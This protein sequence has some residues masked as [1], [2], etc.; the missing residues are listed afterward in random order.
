MFYFKNFCYIAAVE[1][2]VG[3]T[4]LTEWVVA[5]TFI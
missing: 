4:S 5:S 1:T 3:R 2:V